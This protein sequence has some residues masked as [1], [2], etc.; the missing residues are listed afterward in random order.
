MTFSYEHARRAGTVDHICGSLLALARRTLPLAPL[1]LLLHAMDLVDLA[2]ASARA[3]CVARRRVLR[4][5]LAQHLKSQRAAVL[6]LAS[7]T[8]G[9]LKQLDW[10]EWRRLQRRQRQRLRER[11]T[12]KRQRLRQRTTAAAA[13][14]RAQLGSRRELEARSATSAARLEHTGGGR[15]ATRERRGRSAAD[16]RW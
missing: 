2:L 3:L 4:A 15:A 11:A 7:E 14:A 8:L 1:T 13:Q 12:R 5:E 10:R 16:D 9:T 6:Q